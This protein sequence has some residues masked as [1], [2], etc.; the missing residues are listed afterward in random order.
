[1]ALH[2]ELS[3]YPTATAWLDMATELTRNI[4]RAFKRQF[5][6][7]IVNAALE[8]TVLIIEANIARDKTPAIEGVQERQRRTELLVKLFNDKH[9]ISK[10][11]F[12]AALELVNSIGKQAQKWKSSGHLPQSGQGQSARVQKTGCAAATKQHREAN[13]GNRRQLP[14]SPTQFSG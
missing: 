1:M 5:S 10:V 7:L 4:P 12:A 13:Q 8:I 6:E 3:I 2:Y 11:Q 14:R 9:W